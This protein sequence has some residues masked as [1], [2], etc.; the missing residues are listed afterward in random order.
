MAII[1]QKKCDGCHYE[2]RAAGNSIRLYTDGIFHTQWNP[3]RPLAG[4]LW[5]L[6]F[7]PSLYH[8]KFPNLK[9]CLLLGLGG[10]AVVN[11]LNRF[12]QVGEIDAVDLD[13]THLFVAKK[14]FVE[15]K[16]NVSFIQGD[17]RKYVESC[18]VA[19][20]D[21][22]VEDLFCGSSSD[23]SDAVRAF[24]MDKAWLSQLSSMLSDQGILVTNF[25]NLSQLKKSLNKKRV[26]DAGFSAR[27]YMQHPGYEN[28]IG[29][30]FKGVRDNKLFRQRLFHLQAVY[31]KQEVGG[32]NFEIKM[33]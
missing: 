6:L 32:L 21:Y 23:K 12:C 7:L 20:Y 9:R 10:G 29:V 30:C 13:K 2:V 33:L 11:M 22:L 1:W 14:Y 3:C 5:D 28:G 15:Q 8:A 24:D 27:A 4:H 16:K 18:S 17:A 31:R 25:E 19:Q 26:H